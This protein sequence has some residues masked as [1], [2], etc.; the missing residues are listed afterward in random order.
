MK[1]NNLNKWEANQ[2]TI[3]VSKELGDKRKKI[4]QEQNKGLK[5]KVG[6]GVKLA[7][8]DTNGEE[9]LWFEVKEINPFVG[10]CD[11]TPMVVKKVKF[12]DIIP[13]K[14]EEIEDYVKKSNIKINSEELAKEKERIVIL[15]KSQEKKE[16]EEYYLDFI[17]KPVF[18]D[19]NDIS[20]VNVCFSAENISWVSSKDGKYAGGR[21]N[22]PKCSKDE[23]I[24]ELSRLFGD[25]LFWI[26]E[27]QGE[28]AFRNVAQCLYLSEKEINEN[29]KLWRK[30]KNERRK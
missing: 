29:L 11:N 6:D 16:N 15:N 23:F 19:F 22:F 3:P 24:K 9:H 27:N 10:R 2:N 17:L 12:N 1:K 25:T 20:I 21:E 30:E 8:S 7:I 14:F 28:S 18:F 4:W 26:L 5:I 13:F